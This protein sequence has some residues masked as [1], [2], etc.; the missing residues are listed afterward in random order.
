MHKLITVIV[1]FTAFTLVVGEAGAVETTPDKVR[2][3][4]GSKLQSG[5]LL[6]ACAYG[7]D[8]TCGETICTVNCCGGNCPETGCHIHSITRTIGGKKFKI[9]SAAYI[10]MYGRHVRPSSVLRP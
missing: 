2:E 5:C 6:N 8:T 1:A 9:P 7:C 3:I 4:C 10:R